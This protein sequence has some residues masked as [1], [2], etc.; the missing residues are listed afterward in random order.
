M[1]NAYLVVVKVGRQSK[2]GVCEIIVLA[3]IY[4]ITCSE[5]ESEMRAE[6]IIYVCVR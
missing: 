2:S 1:G 6:W 5:S 4:V 3:T